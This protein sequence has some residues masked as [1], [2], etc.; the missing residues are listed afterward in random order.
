MEDKHKE[1]IEEDALADYEDLQKIME[2]MENGNLL[3]E[4]DCYFDKSHWDLTDEDKIELFG[5]IEDADLHQEVVEIIVDC[6]NNLKYAKDLIQGGDKEHG[7]IF[8][9][10]SERLDNIINLLENFI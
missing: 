3:E 7:S 5:S 1:A 2:D 8:N 9:G 6:K 10:Y 4:T